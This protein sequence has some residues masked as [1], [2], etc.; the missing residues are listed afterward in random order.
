MASVDPDYIN[1]IEIAGIQFQ[2]KELKIAGR[3]DITKTLEAFTK[4]SS[5]TAMFDTLTQCTLKYAVDWDQPGSMDA[6]GIEDKLDVMDLLALLKAMLFNGMLTVEDKKK[7][8]SQ[9]LYKDE[10]SVKDADLS[11]SKSYMQSNAQPAMDTD[12]T[13]AQKAISPLT[14][15][16]NFVQ[17]SMMKSI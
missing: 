1:T 13:I 4:Q 17:P 3:R 5:V 14:V 9:P 7:S 15:Q 10:S 16:E 8:E 12:A 6:E 2:V 11:A